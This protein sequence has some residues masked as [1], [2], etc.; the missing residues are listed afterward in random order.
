MCAW[1]L[2]VTSACMSIMLNVG[3]R[4]RGDEGEQF[5]CEFNLVEFVPQP[6]HRNKVGGKYIN[7][8]PLSPLKNIEI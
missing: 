8:S 6:C 2:R 5:T 3:V 7:P 1:Q 4:S